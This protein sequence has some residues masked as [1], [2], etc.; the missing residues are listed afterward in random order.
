MGTAVH[1]MAGFSVAISTGPTM[2]AFE[3][4]SLMS[5]LMQSF[6]AVVNVAVPSQDKNINS[7]GM[8]EPVMSSSSCKA[9][10]IV[11]AAR[12]F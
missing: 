3:N 9:Q 10:F 6:Q 8:L 5:T 1:C 12:Y 4:Q 7:C 2:I 11:P